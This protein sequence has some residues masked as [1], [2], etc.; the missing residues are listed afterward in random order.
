MSQSR[1]NFN[2]TGG[3]K[4]IFSV[5]Q[6]LLVLNECNGH[7]VC[8]PLQRQWHDIDFLTF[9]KESG[10]LKKLYILVENGVRYA[11]VSFI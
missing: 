2:S 5:M 7:D 1:T 10:D 3:E 4:S 11:N 8:A 9:Y 6:L